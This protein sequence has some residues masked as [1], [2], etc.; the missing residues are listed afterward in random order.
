V[1]FLA[2]QWRSVPATNAAER[3]HEKFKR[4]IKTQAVPPNAE[5]AAVRFW[6]LLSSGQ[7]VTRKVDGWQNLLER[8]SHEFIDLVA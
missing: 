7:I 3:L 8:L 4:R 2:S 6:A 1:H 5:I